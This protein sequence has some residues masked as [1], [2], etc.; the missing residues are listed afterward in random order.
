MAEYRT[1]LSLDEDRYDYISAQSGTTWTVNR[2]VEDPLT[3]GVDHTVPEISIFGFDSTTVFNNFN[4]QIIITP[5][6]C[7]VGIPITTVDSITNF[8]SYIS[9]TG[10]N[11]HKIFL[12]GDY[13]SE[14]SVGDYITNPSRGFIAQIDTITYGTGVVPH[15]KTHIYYKNVDPDL[16]DSSKRFNEGEM[17]YLEHLDG[18]VKTYTMD[19][20]YDSGTDEAKLNEDIRVYPIKYIPYF[21]TEFS[22]SVPLQAGGTK[23]VNF[24][25][26]GRAGPLLARNFPAHSLE[27]KETHLTTTQDVFPGGS[28]V[29]WTPRIT[30]DIASLENI[31][32]NDGWH[33]YDVEFTNCYSPTYDTEGLL[34]FAKLAVD[35]SENTPPS[36]HPKVLVPISQNEHYRCKL[37]Y[38]FPSQTTSGFPLTI[39]TVTDAA[40][41]NVGGTQ[42]FNSAT[43]FE[44]AGY[45]VGD[46]IEI[47]AP[48]TLDYESIAYA[49]SAESA[50]GALATTAPLLSALLNE[51]NGSYMYGDVNASGEITS[52]DNLEIL[53]YAYDRATD[54]ETRI[55]ELGTYISNNLS[56][57]ES[58]FLYNGTRYYLMD[59]PA[60]DQQRFTIESFSAPAGAGDTY[61][62]EMDPVGTIYNTT[63]SGSCGLA[64]QSRVHDFSIAIQGFVLPTT[65]RTLETLVY[66]WDDAESAAVRVTKTEIQSYYDDWVGI[67]LKITNVPSDILELVDQ[68][69]PVSGGG[70]GVTQ[71]D[72]AITWTGPYGTGTDRYILSNP[73]R[74]KTNVDQTGWGFLYSLDVGGRTFEANMSGTANRDFGLQVFT[75]SGGTRLN[76]VTNQPRVA[77]HL[78]GFGKHTISKVNL[79]ELQ[80][81]A[82]DGTWHATLQNGSGIYEVKWIFAP[83]TLGGT[84]L[85]VDNPSL[86]YGSGYNYMAGSY[87]SLD[88]E[89]QLIIYRT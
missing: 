35:L 72:N 36:L 68:P 42:Y 73:I 74:T 15:L 45:K 65:P 5:E 2:A 21:S 30:S 66:D 86:T 87:L 88:S 43:D 67:Q 24:K 56:S 39:S 40:I 46:L 62:I 8:S 52:A 55:E 34:E 37:S 77:Y 76:A 11:V 27:D 80:H 85:T 53:K 48:G 82:D 23:T 63:I 10:E 54:H 29:D 33:F 16:G 32:Q 13:T 51:M 19:W 78:T 59:V 89:W 81:A 58:S 14:L 38:K 84:Y 61:K 79:P 41:T 49:V 12:D 7:N 28:T 31:I 47:D 60:Q 57:L 4:E 22:T 1:I 70:T 50:S 69:T 6:D 25:V 26:I 3:E 9:E 64:I 71:F 44:T 75:P 83:G 20:V 17:L 18:V